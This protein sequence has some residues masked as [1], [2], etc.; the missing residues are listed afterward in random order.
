M[1]W[2]KAERWCPDAD[3]VY[4]PADAFVA[5][6]KARLAVTIHDIEV[7]ETDLPWSDT[8]KHKKFRRRWVAKLRDLSP[9]GSSSYRQ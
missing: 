3:W 2:P 7:F 4:S 9:V 8:P 1:R 5:T 6:R